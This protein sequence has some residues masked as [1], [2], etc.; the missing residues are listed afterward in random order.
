MKAFRKECSKFATY[1]D[2]GSMVMDEGISTV[3]SVRTV[4]LL[5]VEHKLETM[6]I[7]Q[8]SKDADCSFI[9]ENRTS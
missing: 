4:R 1:M 3:L 2:E 7:H 5:D 8:T 9:S 6:I